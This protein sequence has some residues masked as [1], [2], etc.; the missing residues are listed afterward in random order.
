MKKIKPLN[1]RTLK[2]PSQVL[3]KAAEIIAVDM[4]NVQYGWTHPAY[5]CYDDPHRD[6]AC[7]AFDKIENMIYQAQVDWWGKD[8]SYSEAQELITPKLELL[9]MAQKT[10]AHMFRGTRRNYSYWFGKNFSDAEQHH[11]INAL[12]LA[13][14][15]MESEGQ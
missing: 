9:E 3:R 14:E 2:K 12:L 8:M 4:Q 7:A 10:F 11:R 6:G 15:A 1:V 13:A 5:T